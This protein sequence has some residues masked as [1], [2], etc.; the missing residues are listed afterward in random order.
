V[1]KYGCGLIHLIHARE[2]NAL[3][4]AQNNSLRRRARLPYRSNVLATNVA[5]GIDPYFVAALKTASLQLRDFMTSPNPLV[6][7]LAQDPYSSMRRYVS[8]TVLDKI[9]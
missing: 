1:L 5:M 6:R 8:Y 7:L 4:V 9:G 2:R 3:S